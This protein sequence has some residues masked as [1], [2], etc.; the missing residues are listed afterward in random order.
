MRH[1]IAFIAALVTLACAGLSSPMPPT[2]DVSEDAVTI[3][4]GTQTLTVALA[5]A[6]LQLDTPYGSRDLVVNISS[7]SGWVQPSQAVSPPKIYRGK[8]SVAALMT[9]DVPN[10]RKLVLHVDAY[11]GIDA[12][13]VKSSITGLYGGVSDC[14]FWAWSET[15]DSYITPTMS[16]PQERKTLPKTTRFDYS[17]WVFLP[18]PTG[19]LAVL[20]NGVVGYL[21]GEPF[22]SALPKSRFLHPGETLDIGFGL[23]GLSDASEAAALS[24]LARGK[25]IPALKRANIR[26]QAKTDYGVPAPGWLRNAD[27]Y[28]GSYGDWSNDLIAKAHMSGARAIVRVDYTRLPNSETQPPATDKLDM[29]DEADPD[30]LLDLA[31]HPD[32]VCI[33]S[34]GNP[35]ESE[36]GL[37]NT[38]LHQADLRHAALTHVCNIMNLG[39]DGIF[40]DNAVPVRECCGPQFGKHTHSNPD[41][42]NT[43]AFEALA[44]EIYK[45]V[46]SF[47][48]DKIVVHNSGIAPSHWSYCDAQMWEGFRFD[49]GASEPVNEWSE[50][51]YA[52]EEHADAVRHGKV[53]VVLT[54]WGSMP[55][56]QCKSGALYTYAFTRLYGWL[57][58]DW[59][60]LTLSPEN[61]NLAKAIYTV[62]LGKPLGDAKPAGDA[63]YRVF[64]KGIVVLNPTRAA[65]SASMPVP[66]DGKLADVAY[67]RELTASDGKLALE[68][69][70]ESGRV[71]VWRD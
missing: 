14:C 70:P 12:V 57:M 22:I 21:P 32:W 68:M 67:D 39:A 5:D 50:L 23:A 33:D 17:D 58:A 66:R 18:G 28:N 11:P 34:Q 52:A 9:F 29:P 30:G 36:P 4:S 25:P 8:D 16:G 53:P 48:D 62:R 20:T 7:P 47:G 44:R 59:F 26:A 54:Y 56:D 37:S 42:T 6:A 35:R 60:D 61:Q 46:K 71:L 40:L 1:R 2:L 45:L 27:M 3:C 24:R 15:L 63:L 51:Q 31:G 69:A 65:V 41:A 13:F 38:C 49:K 64:E 55:A 10:D 43:D 19:G